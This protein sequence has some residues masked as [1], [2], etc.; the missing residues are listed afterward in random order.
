MSIRLVKNPFSDKAVFQNTVF[1]TKRNFA[2][3]AGTLTVPLAGTISGGN[4]SDKSIRIARRKIKNAIIEMQHASQKTLRRVADKLEK[5]IEKLPESE[6]ADPTVW[7][8][9][10]Y[11]KLGMHL[12]ATNA[13]VGAEVLKEKYGMG[14]SA[15]SLME[16]WKEIILY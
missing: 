3:E 6:Q 4:G 1:V 2:S 14:E 5:N 13:F 15:E 11:K 16:K 9:V 12:D 7:L 10:V 8:A